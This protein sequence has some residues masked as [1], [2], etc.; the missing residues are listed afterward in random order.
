MLRKITILTIMLI[1][2]MTLTA[3]AQAQESNVYVR[4]D[5]SEGPIV[6]ELWPDKAPQTVQ[7]FLKYAT[8]NFYTGT[9]FHRVIPGFMI[10]GGGFDVNLIMKK[11]LA[12]ILNEADNGLKNKKYTLAMAR[13]GQPH[14]ATSQF[15]INVAD[16][17]FLNFKAPTG[18]AWG[19]CVFG[20]VVAGKSVV[21]KIEKT[22]T[23]AVGRVHENVPVKPISILRTGLIER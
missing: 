14:S 7:N 15:F 17:A 18:N 5:T 1:G 2:I 4:M 8:S 9:I 22:R 6:L 3:F 11:P 19:Y 16:N 10:Q 12:P 21:D 13:T 23:K 20:Q